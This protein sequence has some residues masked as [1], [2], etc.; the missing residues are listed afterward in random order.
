M[1]FRQTQKPIGPSAQKTRPMVHNPG[2]FQMRPQALVIF[3]VRDP[4]DMVVSIHQLRPDIYWANLRQCLESWNSIK[5]CV[6]H[7]RLVLVRYEDIVRAP[8]E[9]Q[10][11]IT[12]RMPFLKSN[13]QFSS[14]HM[15]STPSLQSLQAM[16]GVRPISDASIG[17]LRS[18]KERLAGQIRL[19]A[20]QISDRAFI[21]DTGAFP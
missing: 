8:D 3:M 16:S 2:T 12:N 6:G 5:S 18:Y 11:K 4:R 21:T 20:L 17:R 13:L 10:R 19:H 1:P 7:Q 15:H 9:I 14:F